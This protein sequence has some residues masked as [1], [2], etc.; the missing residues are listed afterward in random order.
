[1]GEGPIPWA[2]ID[3]WAWSNELDEEARDDVHF[4]VRQLDNTYLQHKA[5]AAKR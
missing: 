2:A 1:M 3:Q 5:K 4:L